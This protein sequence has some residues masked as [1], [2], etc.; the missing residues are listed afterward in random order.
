MLNNQILVDKLLVE[1]T[2][3]DSN[4]FTK[5]GGGTSFVDAWIFDGLYD[6]LPTQ[7]PLPKWT[8]DDAWGSLATWMVS[9]KGT[10]VSSPSW[11]QT[12]V[13]HWAQWKSHVDFVIATNS[14]SGSEVGNDFGNISQSYKFTAGVVAPNGNIYCAPQNAE[15]I[16]KID[17]IAQTLTY[18]GASLGT[19]V[20]K[21]KNCVLGHNGYIYFIPCFATSIIKFNPTT[22]SWTSFG[23]FSAAVNNKWISSTVAPNGCIYCAP[24]S[25]TRILKI[26]PSNGDAISYIG[27]GGSTPNSLYYG[28]VLAPN[29]KIYCIPAYATSVLVIDPS[30]DSVTNIGTLPGGKYQYRSCTLAPNGCIYAIPQTNTDILKIDTNTDNITTFGTVTSTYFSGAC[31]APNGYIYSMPAVTGTANRVLRIDTNTETV[32]ELEILTDYNVTPGGRFNGTVLGPDGCIYGIPHSSTSVSKVSFPHLLDFE[33]DVV[34]A[35]SYWNKF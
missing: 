22:E 3:A 19:A 31:L 8:S 5:S 11:T 7:Y 2:L 30:D 20:S 12:G 16:G 1:K 17:P 10:Y 23:T 24:G 33:N 13:N 15:F 18:V 25:D 21:Y 34:F 6:Y 27:T 32:A 4:F 14:A 35:S 9:G 29:G 26:D 28:S